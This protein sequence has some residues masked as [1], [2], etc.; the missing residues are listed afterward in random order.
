VLVLLSY[1]ERYGGLDEGMVEGLMIGHFLFVVVL[2][3]LGGFLGLIRMRRST[4]CSG[5]LLLLND[6]GSR[7]DFF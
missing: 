3:R 6:L 5:S 7:T 2:R 1:C 4:G